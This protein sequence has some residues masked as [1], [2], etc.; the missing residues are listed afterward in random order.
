MN[1]GAYVGDV[2]H[3]QLSCKHLS[4]SGFDEVGARLTTIRPKLAD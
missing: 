3:R 2:V 1:L 4:I